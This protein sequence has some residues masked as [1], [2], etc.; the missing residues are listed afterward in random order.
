[1]TPLILI[2]AWLGFGVVVVSTISVA[3]GDWPEP[4]DF[5]WWA[6]GWPCVVLVMFVGF[7]KWVVEEWR[8]R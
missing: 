5:F 3:I 7:C 1:M 8:S 6:L 2:L 4:Y